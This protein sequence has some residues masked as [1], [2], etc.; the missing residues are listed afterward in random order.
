MKTLIIINK[1][2]QKGYHLDTYGSSFV[3]ETKYSKIVLCTICL[4]TLGTN[5]LIPIICKHMK[6][7]NIRHSNVLPNIIS[8]Y[9]RHMPHKS[10][11]Q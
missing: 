5:W 9:I 7:I 4:L 10:R 8:S 1:D 6:D 2:N 11:C 3:I